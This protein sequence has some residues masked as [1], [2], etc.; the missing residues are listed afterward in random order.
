MSSQ[1]KLTL[2]EITF[3]IILAVALGLGWSSYNLVYELCN[4][5]LHM[6]GL[7]GLL[8]GLY[9][10]AGIMLP[11]IIRKPGVAILAE[12][13]ASIIETLIGGGFGLTT[14]LYGIIQGLAS[15]VGFA[16]F[17]YRLWNSYSLIFSSIITSVVSFGLSYILY[18]YYKLS[19]WLNLTHLLSSV[20]SAIILTA[21]LSKFLADKL[22]NAGVLNNFNI[23]LDK[24]K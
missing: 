16:L 7:N 20:F 9:L 3:T 18:G 12:L 10:I 22:L 2:S 4:P 5:L 14:V 23:M 6:L 19:F 11:Y 24:L 17:K 8:D 13:V 21:L 15:E 1:N